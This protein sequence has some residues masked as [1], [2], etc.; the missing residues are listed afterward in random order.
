MMS[1]TERTLRI[2]A[3]S[4]GRAA[5]ARDEGK[6]VFVEGAAPGDLVRARLLRDHGSYSEAV[7]TDVLE[8]GPARVT[9]P[10]PIVEQCG[11]CCWQH[12]SYEEQL[13]AKHAAV[14]DALT[15]VGGISSPP[16]EP[17]VPSPRVL[18]YRNRLRLRFDGGRLGFYR[19]RTHSL[20]PIR[21]CLIAEER[22]ASALPAV[23]AFVATLETRVT[24]VEI[25]SRGALP[26]LVLAL[27]SSGR[28][29][30]A[31]VHR[32]RDLLAS[33]DRT[34]RG[35]AMW[36]RGW[37]R[38]WGEVDGS[39]SIEEGLWIDTR[40]ATFGQVNSDAN[41]LL[42]AAVLTATSPAPS[43]H[44]LDLYAGAGNFSLALA[45]RC[46]RVLAVDSDARAVD[47]GRA[48][49]Q[50]QD[51]R[52]VQFHAEPV[53]HF[54]ARA[55][56]R[57]P[58]LLV[59][60][61]PRDGLGAAAESIARLGAPRLVYVSCN[62]STLARDLKVLARAGYVLASARPLDLFPQTF[63]VETVCHARLT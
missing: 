39:E 3:L 28:L 47:I 49:A 25:A 6:V 53:E 51:I 11:G 14:V 41:R 52:N 32:I 42:V 55:S 27:N 43:D 33:A 7:V 35:I 36:G 44:V 21:E 59:V 26:G 31:D 40:G 10:C 8:S 29:R 13:R 57:A 48:C 18:G 1:E 12:V 45:R 62:P 24:R 34:V 63:H 56:Q 54:I 20:V 4:H 16:V 37:R 46:R 2:D 50:R 60:N 38:D 19:A 61:P 17:V 30:R 9:P 23:E 22:I 15:R 5:V 58:D